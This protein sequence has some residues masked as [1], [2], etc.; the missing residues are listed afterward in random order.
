MTGDRPERWLPIAGWEGLYEVSDHG[1]VRSV[2]RSAVAANG[3]TMNWCSVMRR[4]ALSGGGYPAIVLLDGTKG[5]HKSSRIHRL[6]AAAFVP[7]PDNLPQVNHIDGV[8]TNAR[9]DN[10]EWVTAQ[11]NMAHAHKLGL[12]DRKRKKKHP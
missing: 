3:D 12:I 11:Q 10:L 9:A 1:R 5:R 4:P 7:N 6:V 2:Q 8:K